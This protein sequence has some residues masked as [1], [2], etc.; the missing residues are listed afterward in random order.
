MIMFL[1]LNTF[2]PELFIENVRGNLVLV[3]LAAY[4][5]IIQHIDGR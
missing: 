1:I 2:F 4:E 5:G 3:T